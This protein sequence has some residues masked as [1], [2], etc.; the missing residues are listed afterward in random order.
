M[1]ERGPYIS[2]ANCGLPYYVGGEIEEEADLTLQS[3]QSFYARFRIDVRV[4]HE[5]LRIDRQA[6][7]LLIRKLDGGEEYWETYDK[8]ILAPAGRW[9]RPSPA[10]IRSG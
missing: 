2:Y 1:L 5:A 8:L 4:R 6:K 3:P 7:R 9:C 10:W